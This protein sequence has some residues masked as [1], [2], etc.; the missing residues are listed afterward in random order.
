LISQPAF[1]T[2]PAF[3]LFFD[4][5]FEKK[6]EFF[7][8]NPEL[9]YDSSINK[10]LSFHDNDTMHLMSVPILGH[11]EE[12]KSPLYKPIFIMLFPHPFSSISIDTIKELMSSPKCR[13]VKVI[14]NPVR[15]ELNHKEVNY[16]K[17]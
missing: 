13:S 15:P 11:I 3:I 8:N 6:S 2:L 9:G 5:Y 16:I 10:N 7:R 17:L 14:N 1:S 12:C 4:F